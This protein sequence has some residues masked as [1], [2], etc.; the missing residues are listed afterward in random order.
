MRIRAI[1]QRSRETNWA[2]NIH[3]ELADDQQEAL[4]TGQPAA[5]PSAACGG[6]PRCCLPDEPIKTKMTLPVQ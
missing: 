5:K 1:H 3:A 4:N 6:R 2:P